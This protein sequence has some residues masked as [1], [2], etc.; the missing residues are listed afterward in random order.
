MKEF[1]RLFLQKIL[2]FQITSTQHFC[3]VFGQK[4]VNYFLGNSEM[5][6]FVGKVFGKKIRIYEIVL[7]SIFSGIF[8]VDNLCEVV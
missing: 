6:Q 2:Q 1:L 3:K 8:R 7:I 5:I 4:F